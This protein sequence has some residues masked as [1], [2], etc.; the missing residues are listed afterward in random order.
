MKKMTTIQLTEETKK[1]LDS[2]KI[3]PRESYE[4]VINRVLEEDDILTLEEAFKL[5]DK[6][7]QDKIYST[8]E[9]IDL[10]HKNRLRGKL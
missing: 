9:I 5:G 2:K 6:I 8:Q 10:I 3:H 4:E 7:K 1:K